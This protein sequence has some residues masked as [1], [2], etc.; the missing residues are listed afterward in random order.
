MNR[1]V[2]NVKDQGMS[3]QFV[4][5]RLCENLHVEHANFRRVDD[6]T[7][8]K[9]EV[10]SGTKRRACNYTVSLMLTSQGLCRLRLE[11]V[12]DSGTAESLARPSM[13]S[14]RKM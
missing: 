4:K 3:R 1:N 7:G 10:L 13:A 12:L 11:T 14:W 2:F 6:M 8:M 5:K 9:C